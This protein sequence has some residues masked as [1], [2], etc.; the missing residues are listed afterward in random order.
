VNR[1]SDDW[2]F[3]IAYNAA[4]QL[5][6]AALYASGYKPVRGQSHHLRAFQSLQFTIGLD[7]QIVD[8]LETY[9][10]KRHSGTYDRAGAVSG[11]D[12]RAMVAVARLLRM[13]VEEWLRTHY[14]HLIRGR[15]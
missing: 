15:R 4:L 10:V 5:A 9:R 3:S 7:L 8:E 14:P 6:T 13:R 1:I 12:V 2:R 11:A